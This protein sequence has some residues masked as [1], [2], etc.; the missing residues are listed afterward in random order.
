M[1]VAECQ[2]RVSSEEFTHWQA[3]FMLEAEEAK[4]AQKGS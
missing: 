4:A 3:L 2:A 1:S